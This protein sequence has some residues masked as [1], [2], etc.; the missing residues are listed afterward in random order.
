M[1]KLF[2]NTGYK[3]VKKEHTIEVE[4]SESSPHA[5]FEN[6]IDVDPELTDFVE[7]FCLEQVCLCFIHFVFPF[8]N[9]NTYT[10]QGTFPLG[11]V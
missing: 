3:I 7:N 2:K 8:I 6:P 1:R 4:T 10:I 11:I 9:A 5:I